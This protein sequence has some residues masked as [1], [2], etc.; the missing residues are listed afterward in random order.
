MSD[1]LPCLLLP[2]ATQKIVLPT[3]A[4]AEII[5]YEKPVSVIDVPPWLLGML[6]W[7]GIHIPLVSLEKMEHFL[8]WNKKTE[9][10]AAEDISL[11][12]IAILNR[13]DKKISQKA[14]EPHQ[15]PFFSILLK[16]APKLYRIAKDSIKLVAKSDADKRLLLEAR[17]QNDT[18]FVPDLSYLWEII[19]GLPSRLQWFR[20]VVL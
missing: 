4:V 15:Y 12:S 18:V 17:V 1:I 10:K 6:V 9:E 14:G 3:S 7:R 20:Q 11:Y 2:L 13:I 5:V 19:D 8:S 16:G